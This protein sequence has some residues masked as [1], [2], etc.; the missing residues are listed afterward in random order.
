MTF[1]ELLESFH[2]LGRKDLLLK[3]LLDISEKDVLN[4]IHDE[5]N[6]QKYL[7]NKPLYTEI[8]YMLVSLECLIGSSYLKLVENHGLAGEYKYSMGKRHAEYVD[9]R[10]GF[11]SHVS[12][13][14]IDRNFAVDYTLKSIEKVTKEKLNRLHVRSLREVLRKYS[15]DFLAMSIDVLS[16]EDAKKHSS[17]D[18]MNYFIPKMDGH[19]T[20]L[21]NELITCVEKKSQIIEKDSIE[22]LYAVTDKWQYKKEWELINDF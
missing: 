10:I 6:I 1:D 7:R 11:L 17:K 14:W 2:F 22:K 12:Q 18:Y 4:I 3:P 15:Y 16:A 13:L 19:F 9:K 21:V 8:T 5:N 20:K